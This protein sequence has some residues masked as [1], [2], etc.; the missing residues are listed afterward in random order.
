MSII[1][2]RKDTRF[3][4]ASNESFEDA[5]LSWE[6]RGLMG[7]L[8][9][10]PDG[11]EVRMADLDKNGPA[12]SRKLKRMLAELRKCGYMNR[13][14]IKLPD[15][16]FT[17]T[18]EVFESPSQNPNPST[19]GAFC[20]SALSTSAKPPDIVSTDLTSTDSD[21]F[22]QNTAKIFQL[23]A[24][25]FGN[26][27]ERI[28]D[29]IKDTEQEYPQQWV[30][31]AMQIAVEANK[32]SWGYVKGILKRSR[33]KNKSPKENAKTYES[34]EK[35][36][37]KR[38]EPAIYQAVRDFLATEETSNDGVFNLSKDADNDNDN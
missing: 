34:Y 22:K 3:F 9:S 11:W 30:L 28:A 2:T 31:E 25:D 14:R 19:S 36:A 32:Q 10:K 24:S 38:K 5:R 18:T 33:E 23:Y 1:R 29:T 16:T 17:W 15:G 35:K 6:A 7:Y 8:L 12:G 20:T 37:S 13:I 4:A 27:T 26:I 21:L